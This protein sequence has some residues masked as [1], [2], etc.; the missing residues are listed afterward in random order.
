MIGDKIKRKIAEL[1]AVKKAREYI[2][3]FQ[4]HKKR[5][6]PYFREDNEGTATYLSPHTVE[7]VFKGITPQEGYER[8]INKFK[9]VQRLHKVSVMLEGNKVVVD[10]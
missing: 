2:L 7:L 4:E 1:N 10:F 5:T 3:D 6:Y 8:T 9:L